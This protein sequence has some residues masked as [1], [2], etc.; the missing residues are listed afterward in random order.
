[1]KRDDGEIQIKLSFVGDLKSIDLLMERMNK[2]Q[3][4]ME[5][6]HYFSMPFTAIL[7]H[8]STN[9]R[10]FYMFFFYFSCKLKPISTLTHKSHF[11][12]QH[13]LFF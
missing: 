11:C 8:E 12:H 2:I 7:H 3:K 6:K 10:E 13:Y 4:K 5:N 9:S 1:M